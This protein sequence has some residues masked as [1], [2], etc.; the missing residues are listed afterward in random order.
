[1]FFFSNESVSNEQEVAEPEDAVADGDHELRKIA[2]VLMH[3]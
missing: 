1:M 3:V 2:D